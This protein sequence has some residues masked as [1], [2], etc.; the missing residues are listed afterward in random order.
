M[1]KNIKPGGVGIFTVWAYEQES[2]GRKIS[3]QD[4]MITWHL[5]ERFD[6][7]KS[8]CFVRHNERK[9]QIYTRDIVICLK[10]VN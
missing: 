4:T 2:T 1:F 8:K 9:R 10:R 5:Q 7:K 6:N 3:E